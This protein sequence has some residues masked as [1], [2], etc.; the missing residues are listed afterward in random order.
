MPNRRVLT[1]AF[2]RDRVTALRKEEV[3]HAMYHFRRIVLGERSA[4]SELEHFGITWTD[5]E[6]TDQGSD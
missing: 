1:I 3:D 2:D 6:D 5:D 4:R